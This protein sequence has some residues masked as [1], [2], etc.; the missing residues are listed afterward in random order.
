MTLLLLSGLRHVIDNVMTTYH[1][2]LSVGTSNVAMRS[3][4][5]MQIFLEIKQTLKPIKWHLKG[6][7]INKILHW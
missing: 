6:H 5:T 3:V 2:T 1:I 4:T 7:M